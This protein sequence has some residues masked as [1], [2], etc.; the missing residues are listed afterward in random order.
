MYNAVTHFGVYLHLT[1]VFKLL[2]PS[3][4]VYDRHRYASRCTWSSNKRP[5]LFIIRI[6]SCSDI[7][8]LFRPAVVICLPLP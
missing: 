6:H 5:A 2:T 1:N 4:A 8:Q 7:P 3:G